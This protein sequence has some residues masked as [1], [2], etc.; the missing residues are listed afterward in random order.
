MCPSV[1]MNSS[2]VSSLSLSKSL[3]CYV[4]LFTTKTS[5]RVFN[6]E[7][8]KFESEDP[9]VYQ[10]ETKPACEQRQDYLGYLKPHEEME[11]AAVYT[12]VCDCHIK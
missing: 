11:V 6:A 1:K 3:R 7:D 10:L 5:A 9:R 2:S 8:T 12:L 4:G